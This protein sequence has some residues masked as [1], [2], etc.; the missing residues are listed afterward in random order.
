LSAVIRVGIFIILL[1]S[2]QSKETS[3][4]TP[5][6]GDGEY[7]SPEE[8]ISASIALT[9]IIDWPEDTIEHQKNL[10]IN[11]E[12]AKTLILPLH[13]LWDKK[14]AEVASQIPTW[15][16]SKISDISHN[17][18]KRCDCD[19]YQ[20]VLDRNPDL[21]QNSFAGLKIQKTKADVLNCL[22]N[23]PSLQKI[24]A[25]LEKERKD[26]EVKDTQ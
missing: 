17:C 24:R 16:Q 20:E 14:I 4:A 13:P 8:V 26:Y 9:A 23:M 5:F 1:A 12:S 19:F 11:H 18:L 15:D 10:M 2:C 3:T 22:K 7:F 25:Y 6:K 21:N